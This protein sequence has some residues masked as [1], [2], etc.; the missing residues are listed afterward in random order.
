MTYN[1]PQNLYIILKWYKYLDFQQMCNAQ[2]NDSTYTPPKFNFVKNDFQKPTRW[3]RT[4]YAYMADNQNDKKY[5]V[6]YY[7]TKTI[8][9]SHSWVFL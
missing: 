7:Y 6:N 1:F 3:R 9:L 5:I 4:D 8:A 2:E